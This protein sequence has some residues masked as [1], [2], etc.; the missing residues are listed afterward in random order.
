M[1]SLLTMA[2]KDLTLMRRDWLGMFFIIGFPVLM[3]VFFGLISGSFG[4]GGGG[5]LEVAS[6]DKDESEMAKKVGESLIKNEKVDVR[7]LR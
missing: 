6:V 3:G 4:G 5:A 2:V 7:V 1:R